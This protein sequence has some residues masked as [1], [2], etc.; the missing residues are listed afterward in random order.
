MLMKMVLKWACNLAI[1]HMGAGA[2]SKIKVGAFIK[3]NYLQLN[4]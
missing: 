2:L 3:Q 1:A 4:V